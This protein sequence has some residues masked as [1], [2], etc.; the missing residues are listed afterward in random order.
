MP[1]ERINVK[2]EGE[3]QIPSLPNFLEVKIGTGSHSVPVSQFDAR[4][5]T[6]VAKRWRDALV[7]KAKVS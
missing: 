2:L 5:L 4:T 6:D 1:R 7:A 3:V